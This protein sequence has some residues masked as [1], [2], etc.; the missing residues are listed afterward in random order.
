MSKATLY[1]VLLLFALVALSSVSAQRRNY[2][3]GKGYRRGETAIFKNRKGPGNN[4]R[5]F[6]PRKP[7]PFKPQKKRKLFKPFLDRQFRLPNN[8]K[9]TKQEYDLIPPPPPPPPTQRVEPSQVFNSEK[10]QE[11]IRIIEELNR[12]RRQPNTP[13]EINTEQRINPVIRNIPE[14]TEY[15][16]SSS[17]NTIREVAQNRDSYYIPSSPSVPYEENNYAPPE[18]RDLESAVFGQADNYQAKN[19]KAEVFQT[20][21]RLEFQIHGHEGPDSYRYG[22]DTGNGYNRQFRYEEKDKNGLVNGRYGYF[23]PYGKLH[24]VNYISH[25]E[26][27]YKASG[28]GVPTF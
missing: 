6:D 7:R 27:G 25:P 20:E 14:E 24:V 2:P 10:N 11:E 28:D 4:G 13:V 15:Q 12:P 1:L 18:Q 17:S 26:H 16:P 22:Y 19:E 5:F 23:D 8:N 9:Q 3:E 21:D